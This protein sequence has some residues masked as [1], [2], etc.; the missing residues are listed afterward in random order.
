MSTHTVTQVAA[1]Y[2]HYTVF[3]TDTGATYATGSNGY[4]QLGDGS[5]VNKATP[6]L[7]MASYTVT[8]VAA[9][10][11]HTVFLTDTGAVYAT[12]R[13]TN[14]QLGDGPTVDKNTPVQVMSSYTVTQV[15]AGYSHTVF[16]TTA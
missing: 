16:L 6:V 15:Y 1:G 14:G 5:T 3:L 8:Q 13:N 4:G 9:G 2:G 10:Y 11:Y 12:G 7:V